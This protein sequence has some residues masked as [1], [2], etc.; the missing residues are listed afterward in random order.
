HNV[1]NEDLPQLL[2]SRGGS[3]V[4]NVHAFDVEDFSICDLENNGVSISQAEIYESETSRFTIH[5]SS[6]KALISN[7]YFQDSDSDVEK[8]TRS[9]SEFLADL[10]VEFHD[11]AFLANHKRFYKRSGRVGSAKKTMDKSNE[12]CFACGKLGHFQKECLTTKTYTPSYPSSKKSY[13][14]L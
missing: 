2:D 7:T 6:S 8:D 5:A 12:T 9:S 1:V 4:T 13:N 10:N 14:K 3:H 11:K